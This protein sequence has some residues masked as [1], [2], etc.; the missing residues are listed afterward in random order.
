MAKSPRSLFKFRSIATKLE[1][2]RILDAI[3]NQRLYAA[4]SRA[5]NDPMEGLVQVWSEKRQAYV[6]AGKVVRK[7]GIRVL[8]LSDGYQSAALWSHYGDN[9]QGVAIEVAP[10]VT[11]EIYQVRYQDELPPI[12]G[13]SNDAKAIEYLTRKYSSWK[14]E[15]EHR[16]LTKQQWVKCK[17]KSVTFG[18]R[19]NERRLLS[20]RDS[21]AETDPSVACYQMYFGGL[22]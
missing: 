2:E 14:Y 10:V 13:Q 19:A 20:L 9:H 16:V 1:R 7:S 17:V 5:L 12:F 18:V 8:S 15:K 3:R 6:F 11:R 22:G 4:D 21:I